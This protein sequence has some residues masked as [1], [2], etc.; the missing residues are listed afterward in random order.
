MSLS[1]DVKPELQDRVREEARRLSLD[2]DVLLSEAIQTG[3]ARLALDR[4]PEADVPAVPS[5]AHVERGEAQ[6]ERAQKNARLIA[7]LHSFEEGD[8]EQQRRD[9]AILQAGLEE[10]RPGQRRLFSEGVNP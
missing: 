3:L 4:A 2:P 5:P 6:R 8:A 10:A 9:L 1:L 7:R